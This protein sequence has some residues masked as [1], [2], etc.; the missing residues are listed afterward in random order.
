MAI[1]GR[2]FRESFLSPRTESII[3]RICSIVSSKMLWSFPG[4]IF[5]FFFMS[6]PMVTSTKRLTKE[7]RRALVTGQPHSSKSSS[8]R[9]DISCIWVLF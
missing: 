9:R 2:Y 6:R 1:K 3:P 7:S 5:R 4:T 8:A